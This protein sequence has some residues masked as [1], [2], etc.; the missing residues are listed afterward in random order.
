MEKTGKCLKEDSK[1]KR[2]LNEILA[3][4]MF[5]LLGAMAVAVY[6]VN[7]KALGWQGNSSTSLSV[8]IKEIIANKEP[9]VL[10]YASPETAKY[11][12]SVGGNY[13]V[14]LKPW[15]NFFTQ[16]KIPYKEIG[17]AQK[18]SDPRR[19]VLVLPS[20]AAIGNEERA[21]IIAFQK[22]GGNIFATSTLGARSG[23]GEW[24]GYEYVRKLLGVTVTGEVPPD[25]EQR[26]LNLFGDLPFGQT[27]QPGERIWLGKLGTNPLRLQGGKTAASLTDWARSTSVGDGEASAVLYDEFGKDRNY[28]RWVLL[29]F[30][31]TS[32]EI[33]RNAVH[34]MLQ[35]ALHWLEHQP[36]IYKASW[37][38]PYRAAQFLEMDTEQGF[39][40]ALRFAGML[41]KF[42]IPGTFFLLTSEAKRYP[43]IVKQLARRHEIAYHGDVHDGFR[44]QSEAVQSQRMIN[45]QADM[46]SLLGS[47]DRVTGFRAPLESY[48]KTTEDLLMKYKLRQHAADPN[49][50]N[51][52]VPLFY[53]ADKKNNA[54]SLVVLPRTEFDDINLIKAGHNE[55]S[56]IS[57]TLINELNQVIQ[58]GGLGFISIHT[59]NFSEDNPLA[60][61][62]PT[63]LEY[64]NNQRQSVW[65][66]ESRKIA[67]W[68]RDREKFSYRVMNSAA[69]IDLDVTIEGAAPING[70][71]LIV[72]NPY[73]N[74]ALRVKPVKTN[75]PEPQIKPIDDLRTAIIFSDIA[76]GTYSYSITFPRD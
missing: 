70:A 44:G 11:L 7:M 1:G 71:S 14:L 47:I 52:R 31:E 25:K 68:W 8:P 19:S 72:A 23:S 73:S 17:S 58:M 32:W 5:F 10:L 30:P 61:A 15:R 63:Y 60:Q 27:Y 24:T 49:R 42:N 46:K 48:D 54:Q 26:H 6:A 29:S 21:A 28:S 13:E 9:T 36:A 20:V 3:L 40:N 37:P 64:L 39:P 69:K 34:E 12:Q 43:E 41:D 74:A 56:L 67:D 2:R 59:Q 62:M 76:P 16:Q 4:L 66:D 45:M 55:K 38:F 53:P 51:A 33:Q 57:E 18:I 75:M 50:S 22:Q 35:N 65:V